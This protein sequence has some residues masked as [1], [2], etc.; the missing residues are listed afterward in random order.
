MEIRQLH[1]FLAAAQTQN[2]RKAAD[3]CLIAQSALS[4]QIAALESELGV[5]LFRRI[6]RRVSLTTAG[7][8]FALYARQALEHLQKGQEALVE[9]EA[10]ERGTITLG[11]IEA[12]ATAYLPPIFADFSR[13]HP[14]IR[15]KVKVGGADDLMRMVEQGSLDFGLIFDPPPESQLVSVREIIRQ[16]IQLITAMNYHL[17]T[18]KGPLLLEDLRAEPLA[19][20][21]EG[22]GMRRILET[23]YR[24]RG[25]NL[26]PVVEIDSI[27]A[28]KEFVKQ[29]VGITFMPT[30]L[31]RPGQVNVELAVRPVADLSQEYI[32]G[33][34]QRRA[35]TIS[36]AAHALIEAITSTIV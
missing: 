31:I 12:L 18:S 1:Y 4:R 2:F 30:A 27:E 20:L 19:I 36:R 29:G 16:P 28:L 9:L 35:G 32:F 22:F 10:G 21:G 23:I 7:E 25:F 8:E 33:L 26:Q 17:K 11:C 34:V 14:F 5:E 13:R 15:L 24:Q 3:L 6:E